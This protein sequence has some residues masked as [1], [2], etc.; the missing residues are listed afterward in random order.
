MEDFLL[1]GGYY[2]LLL[3]LAAAFLILLISQ[4]K[5]IISLLPKISKSGGWLLVFIILVG[6]VLRLTAP[7]EL[8]IYYDEFYYLAGAQNLKNC[9][10]ATYSWIA[11]G[12]KTRK[13]D[14]RNKSGLATGDKRI[15]LF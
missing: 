11:P 3:I 6:A 15:F 7:R 5:N 13:G 2:F 1:H 14:R 8:Q 10:I 4:S 12:G 9:F